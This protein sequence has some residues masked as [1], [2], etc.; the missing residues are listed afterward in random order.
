MAQ[1]LTALEKHLISKDII[2]SDSLNNAQKTAKLSNKNILEIL[3]QTDFIGEK[4]LLNALSEYFQMPK[5]D[6]KN[7]NAHLMPKNLISDE[8]IITTN[9][10]LPVEL[11]ENSNKR[12]VTLVVSD[13]WSTKKIIDGLRNTLR[14]EIKVYISSYSQLA[15]TIDAN[16]TSYDTER[17]TEDDLL[18]SIGT[19]NDST[20][21]NM[22][23]AITDEDTDKPIAIYI[24]QTLR[25]AVTRRASDL[26]FEPFEDMYRIRFRID[27]VL[28]IYTQLPPKVGIR[29][30]ARIK[31]ISQMDIAEKRNPQDGRVR[32]KISER[33]SIDFRVNSLP[34]SFGE[35]IVMRILDSSSTKIGVEYLGFEEDQRN[36]Y[37]EA[38]EK[39][40][41]LILITGPTGSGKTVSL[42]TGLN[43]L[44]T[45][46]RNISTAED[47]VE[48]NVKGINQVSINAKS[49]LTFAHTLRA[50][51]RQDPDVIMVGEIR[52]LETAEISIKAAQTG[53]MVLSTLHTNSAPETLTRLRNM[54]VP[55][56]NIAT[57]VNLVIAQ[58]LARQLCSVCKRKVEYNKSALLEI[59][60]IESDFEREDFQIYESVGCGSCNGGYKGRVGIYEVMPI[61]KEISEIIMKDGNSIEIASAAKKNGV[62][63]LRRSGI[64]K[65]LSG[66][67]S[68]AEL[69]RV[70]SD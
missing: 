70:T 66:K 30:I 59:G 29:I 31:V 10:I 15:D 57:S 26:H 18:S 60:F 9:Q 55:S 13:P 28:Q 67:T 64:L 2:N 46:E 62:N 52:D 3:A 27:G 8:K 68:L 11:T 39:P 65:V 4:N 48:I 53:H 61:T 36:L 44:N 42:Y 24:N 19:T 63:N 14:A 38:L 7:F 43:I 34:T 35:K 47:P 16:F 33:R 56:F 45:A 50:F 17:V 51:L 49:G 25:E 12:V 32:L 41:G 5:Y 21:N 54:G 40:Q 58:R 69:M 23:Q 6:W 20:D 1:E 37:L 22:M